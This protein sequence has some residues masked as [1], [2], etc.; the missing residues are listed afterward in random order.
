M[1]RDSITARN[2]CMCNFYQ[3]NQPIEKKKKFNVKI[4]IHK[5]I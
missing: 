1:L 5:N 3:K 2:F 4:N